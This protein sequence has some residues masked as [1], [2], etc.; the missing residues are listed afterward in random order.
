MN[1]RRDYGCPCRCLVCDE[2]YWWEGGGEE[3][4]AVLGQFSAKEWVLFL[5]CLNVR[6]SHRYILLIPHFV[7]ICFRAS[8]VFVFNLDLLEQL[9]ACLLLKKDSGFRHT[10]SAM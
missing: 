3:V 8:A 7:A 2:V 1:I 9:M 4:S 5:R 6:N 10:A